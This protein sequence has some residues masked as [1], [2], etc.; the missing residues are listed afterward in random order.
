L[1]GPVALETAVEA[2]APVLEEARRRG[3]VGP[4]P[5]EDHVRHAWPL[6][7]VLPEAGVAVDLGSGGGVPAL[8][9]AWA[10]PRL[11][12]VLV[13]SQDRRARWLH[14]A[15]R[16]AGMAERTEVRQERAEATG[17]ST[18]RGQADVVTA[19]SFATPAVTA[20]CATG[21]LAVGGVLW[22]AEPP[23]EALNRWDGDVLDE[24]G[25]RAVDG[26]PPGWA[27]FEQVR[28][29]PDRY[30]RRVGIPSKRPLF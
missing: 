21:L 29:C 25:L 24:L 16:R 27:G 4:G 13:E 15:A 5:V 14:E 1:S 7:P 17:R 18:L 12:W 26:A 23:A 28:P 3:F 10:R 30:P 22:V 9:L 20:E 19:R 6:V 2:L 11:R 8:V